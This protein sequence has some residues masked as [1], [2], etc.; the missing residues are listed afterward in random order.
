MFVNAWQRRETF[1]PGRGTLP[2]WLIGIARHK[3]VD[4]LRANARQPSPVPETPESPTEDPGLERL[5]DRLLVADALGRLPAEQRMALELAFFEG[6][7]HSEVAQRLDLPLGT[8]KSQIRRGLERL[9]QHV[10]TGEGSA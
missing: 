8:V 4:R 7:S 10:S 2:G 6:Y 9:R 3:V 5:A 1:D